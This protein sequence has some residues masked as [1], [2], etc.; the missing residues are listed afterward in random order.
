MFIQT[1][2]SLQLAGRYIGDDV[3]NIEWLQF[4]FQNCEMLHSVWGLYD[5]NSAS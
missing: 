2:H 1:L 3:L 5:K 4:I